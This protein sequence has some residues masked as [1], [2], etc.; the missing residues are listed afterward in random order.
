MNLY[1]AFIGNPLAITDPYGMEGRKSSWSSRYCGSYRSTDTQINQYYEGWLKKQ[2]TDLWSLFSSQRSTIV[3]QVY[4]EQTEQDDK[5]KEFVLHS[6]GTCISLDV[7]GGVPVLGDLLL[8]FPHA[9]V[10]GLE[11]DGL[12]EVLQRMSATGVPLIGIAGNTYHATLTARR[13]AAR[14]AMMVG[15]TIGKTAQTTR[16][17]DKTRRVGNIIDTSKSVKNTTKSGWTKLSSNSFRYVKDIEMQT[18]IKIHS[19]QRRLLADALRQKQY[20]RLSKKVISAN[21]VKF[22]QIRG[23]LIKQWEVNTGQVWPKYSQDVTNIHGTTLR[24]AGQPYDAHHIIESNYGGPNVWWNIHPA[25]FPNQHQAGI[26]RAGG[27]VREVL[28]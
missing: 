3:P 26:H 5:S 16:R 11:N 2:E 12:S 7:S 28:P 27:V 9:V 18:G 17:V 10:H 19:S 8:D 21:R 23:D 6:P 4:S 22:G 20:T 15:E 25:A 14:K 24:H 13:I 1:E